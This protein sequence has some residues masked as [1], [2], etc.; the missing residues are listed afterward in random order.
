MLKKFIRKTRSFIFYKT[1]FGEFF[2]SMYDL[3]HHLKYSFN[4]K[5][6]HKDKDSFKYYLTKQYHII[7]KGLS[8]PETRS[9]FGQPK[10][11]NVIEKAQKYEKIYG[12]DELTL[13]IRE[14]L[15]Q[16]MS[17]NKDSELTNVFRLTVNKYLDSNSKSGSGK[18][19]LK[20]IDRD[21]SST[22]NLEEFT[23]FA[24][25]RV[26]VRNFSNENVSI[27][28]LK[29]ATEAAQY[30][31]S[32]CNRQSW[33][34]HCYTDKSKIL[35]IL[36]YQNG[37]RGFSNVINKLIIVTSDAKGFTS[38]EN[39][40]RFIDGGLFSMNLLLAIHAAGLGACPLNTCYPYIIEKKV[41]SVSGIP[42]NERL[43]MM[44]GIGCLKEKYSVAYSAR[45]PID[46]VFISH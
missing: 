37:N 22:L 28:I 25:S 1:P 35:S 43:I 41:K 18:G 26:S 10:I 17:I 36:S 13:S 8:L 2:S 33:K 39:N 30:A 44:I 14:T 32:V 38:F 31:P 12:S 40:Q 19:G 7:E 23:I 4:T 9:G 3:N 27:G 29:A 6:L 11:T 42:D 5:N 45:N 24:K 16:Y 34:V 46:N 20:Y 21:F 15:K